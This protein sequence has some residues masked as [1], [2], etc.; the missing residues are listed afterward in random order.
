MDIFKLPPALRNLPLLIRFFAG[1]YLSAG[2]RGRRGKDT[3][4]A[5]TKM[6]H[7]YLQCVLLYSFA[8]FRSSLISP[9]PEHGITLIELLPL[10]FG[11]CYDSRNSRIPTKDK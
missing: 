5:W 6:S 8:C 1:M 4:R 3:S 7:V 10:H 2:S 9:I 11:K